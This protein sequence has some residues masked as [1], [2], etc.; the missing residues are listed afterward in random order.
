VTSAQVKLSEKALSIPASITLEVT[1]LAQALKA[2][3]HDVIAFAAGEPDLEAPVAVQDAGIE[4]IQ[5]G[6]GRYTAAAGMPSLREAVSR[7]FE[8]RGLAYP[9][10]QVMATAGAKPALFLALFALL[11]DGDECIFPSPYWGSYTEI[12]RAAGGVPRSFPTPVEQDFQPDPDALRAAL[13]DRTR[14]L[15]LNSPNNPTGTVYSRETLE[16]LAEVVRERDL[17][18]VTDD[19]YEHLIY[20]GEPFANILNVAEDLVDRTVIVNG[21]SKSH[22]MTGWRMG[23]VGGPKPIIA[24]MSRIQSQIAGNPPTISQHAA[25]AA[26][27][28]P[29]P[30]ERLASLDKRR[31]V[32]LSELA[33]IDGL[34]CPE[35]RGAFYA[36][37]SIAPWLGRSYKGREISDASDLAKVLLEEKLVATVSGDAFGTPGHLRLTYCTS[38]SNIVEGVGRLAEFLD[39]MS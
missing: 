25:L 33:K 2:Q 20:T 28:D 6:R 35:P 5:E 30:P 7:Y 13:T 39:Q 10:D 31:R 22:S 9:P 27:A 16:A 17:C 24:A 37:P 26:F 11:D 8:T 14:V 15:M 19:I 12:V 29:L 32:L 18:V 38:E 1:A 4:A 3:G 23:F 36:F 21:L 34:V